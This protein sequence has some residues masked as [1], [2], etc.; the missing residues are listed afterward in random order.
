M[1]LVVVIPVQKHYLSM[2]FPPPQS[3]KQKNVWLK[4]NL[5]Q[6]GNLFVCDWTDTSLKSQ[7]VVD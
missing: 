4:F 2:L 1:T 3:E 5:L 6:I 7:V